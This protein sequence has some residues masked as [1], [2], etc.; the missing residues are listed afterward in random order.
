MCNTTI[1]EKKD[2]FTFIYVTNYSTQLPAET[3]HTFKK[4]CRTNPLLHTR[5]MIYDDKLSFMSVLQLLQYI[6]KQFNGTVHQP[7]RLNATVCTR[8]HYSQSSAVCRYD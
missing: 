7:L 4:K 1:F 6:L 8:C 2:L 3:N 5:F